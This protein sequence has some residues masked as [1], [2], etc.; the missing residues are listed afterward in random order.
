MDNFSKIRFVL[1][2]T[3]S[4]NLLV[5]VAKIAVGYITGSLSIVADGFDSFFDS[6]TNVI[7]LIA[8]YLSHQPPD[9]DHPY[10]HRRYEVLLTLAISV[11]LFFSCFQILRGAYERML[12][13]AVPEVTVWSFAAL[14]LSIA[15]QLYTS[16]YEKRRG[17][18]LKSEFLIADASHTRAD[19]FITLGVV[20]GLVVVKMGYPFIDTILAVIIAAVIAKIGV[21]IIRNSTRILTD[22]AVL[23]ID[24]VAAIVRS[25]PGI[26]SCHH[27]RS[28][29][30]AGD[31]H[32]DLHIRVAP[33]MPIAQAHL[34]AH[35]VQSK[36][37]QAIEGVRDVIVHIEP[38]P[39]MPHAANRDLL[40]NL[41]RVAHNMG[42][43]IHHLSAHEVSGQYFVDLHFGVP[44]TMT[45][46]EAHAQAS[47]LEDRIRA[48]MPQVAEINT[49]I[50]PVTP[51]VL[52]RCDELPE[53]SQ[54][55][56]RVR[57]LARAMP[58][59]RGCHQIKV[60]QMADGIFV[61][62]HCTLGEHLPIVRAHDIATLIEERL[63]REC[64]GIT[65]V[66]V[67][68]EPESAGN[69]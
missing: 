57:E 56:R 61:T 29:G 3:L 9:E 41:R 11:L 1:L 25:V 22:A 24:R 19:I 20:G 47:Q 2:Y 36:L 45:L 44:E 33:E 49:H 10:G 59:V 28:R 8:I 58:E 21:D 52:A 55:V 18:E 43:T 12:H 50:E 4:L 26:E 69:N 17:K 34:V 48:G 66:S 65:R 37:Q 27:I 14:F 15:T 42:M 16:S 13:P 54:I 68:M 46:E 31:I 53:E 67:H 6:V 40:T 23:D 39:G 60:Y 32:L 30:Q 5:T 38:Q 7:G 63:R 64:S 62:M 35:R 51:D